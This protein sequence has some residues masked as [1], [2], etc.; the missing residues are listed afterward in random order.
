MPS[1]KQKLP[2]KFPE[3]DPIE[4]PA[5]PITKKRSRGQKSAGDE[6]KSKEKGKVPVDDANDGIYQIEVLTRS[7]MNYQKVILTSP[8]Q[9]V[10]THR[11]A[12]V[13]GVGSTDS[14]TMLSDSPDV[15]VKDIPDSR[16]S[17]SSKG[18]TR[19]KTKPGP[20]SSDLKSKLATAVTTSMVQTSLVPVNSQG[21]VH[22]MHS[23]VPG[24]DK[25]LTDQDIGFPF[26]WEPSAIACSQKDATQLA[27]VCLTNYFTWSAR[28]SPYWP[29]LDKW[30]LK[31]W[32]D[33]VSGNVQQQGG[34][35][36]V[37]LYAKMF[38]GHSSPPP[39]ICV[40]TGLVMDSFFE[41]RLKF[42]A[43]PSRNIQESWEK[44]LSI[45]LFGKELARFVSMQHVLTGTMKLWLPIV[46]V[47]FDLNPNMPIDALCF[48]LFPGTDSQ[49]SPVKLPIKSAARLH[50]DDSSDEESA[51]QTKHAGLQSTQIY[52]DYNAEVLIYDGC[53]AQ[54]ISKDLC[55]DVVG[56][57]PRWLSINIPIGCIVT[58][59]H[60]VTKFDTS[61]GEKGNVS[62][63]LHYVVVLYC[64]E[65]DSPM[66]ASLKPSSLSIFTPLSSPSKA[67]VM[68]PST[69]DNKRTSSFYSREYKGKGK[70][71]EVMIE[72]EADECEED[73]DGDFIDEEEQEEERHVDDVSSDDGG[74]EEAVE[75]E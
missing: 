46:R 4:P 71:K 41:G 10:D 59:A 74:E 70:C 32:F 18:N 5:T 37:Y 65:E 19:G 15:D 69:P 12:R 31:K 28:K 17:S 56:K 26:N 21:D 62:Y 57:L 22:V 34:K 68:P 36:R 29:D 72:S 75:S 42:S 73:D 9:T 7:I 14:S 16:P 8:P 2:A 3:D 23:K 44:G 45:H 38:A 60:T 67:V 6:H 24:M 25:V 58:I 1:R 63:N 20:K 64:P 55:L 47:T 52:L 49:R 54:K 43:D 48:S 35:P 66:P 40:T 53:N 27:F 51:Q 13:A 39:V 30:Q 11:S 50:L 61:D 33:Q